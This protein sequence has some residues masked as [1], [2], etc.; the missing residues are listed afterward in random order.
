MMNQSD[1]IT[2]HTG[3]YIAADQIVG[4]ADYNNGV[5]Y[6]T[7]NG[8]EASSG[9]LSLGMLSLALLGLMGYYALTRGRQM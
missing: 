3:G 6:G 7:G 4:N 1:I 5:A 8:L 2:Y 9:Q